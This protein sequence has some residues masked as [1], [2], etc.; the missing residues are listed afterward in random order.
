RM[1][2]QFKTVVPASSAWAPTIRAVRRSRPTLMMIIS[3]LLSHRMCSTLRL[4]LTAGHQRRHPGDQLPPS[5]L[6]HSV[7]IGGA[8][9]GWLSYA[10]VVGIRLP[11]RFVQLRIG[12]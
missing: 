2:H 1:V 4:W 3:V 8:T 9:T 7:A 5:D 12:R 11:L 10:V 6:R